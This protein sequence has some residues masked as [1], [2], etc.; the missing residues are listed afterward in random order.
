MDKGCIMEREILFS[1]LCLCL[2][3]CGG[4]FNNG[5]G[6]FVFY[7]HILVFKYFIKRDSTFE[8]LNIS[9]SYFYHFAIVFFQVHNLFS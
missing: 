7:F 1:V 6:E 2:G 4:A 9:S 5:I 8:I 3:T